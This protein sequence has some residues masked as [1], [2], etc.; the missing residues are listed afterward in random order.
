VR[1]G[2]GA[3]KPQPQS[4]A[5]AQKADSRRSCRIIIGLASDIESRLGGL[6]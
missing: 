3:S 1:W 5:V 4:M 6:S 2:A